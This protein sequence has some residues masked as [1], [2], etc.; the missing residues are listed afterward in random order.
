MDRKIKVLERAAVMHVYDI[1]DFPTDDD[2]DP[3]PD[4]L[5]TYE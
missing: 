4:D 3:F 1:D 2:F 5:P